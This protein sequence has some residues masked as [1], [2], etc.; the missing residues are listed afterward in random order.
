MAKSNTPY[1]VVE[2][3]AKHYGDGEARMQV[4]D[5][6]TTTVNRGEICSL[7]QSRAQ[8]KALRRL[9]PSNSRYFT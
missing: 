9:K 2:G 3:L 4:L 5:G 1:L 6:I 7:F 8:A